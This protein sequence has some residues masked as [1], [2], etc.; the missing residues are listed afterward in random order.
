MN[1]IC[2]KESTSLCAL[3][4]RELQWAYSVGLSIGMNESIGGG[5]ASAESPCIGL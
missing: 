1:W 5:N 3:E 2:M 4:W